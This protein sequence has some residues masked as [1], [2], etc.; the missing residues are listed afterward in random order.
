MTTRPFHSAWSVYAIN[1]CIPSRCH[2]DPVAGE[3]FAFCLFST[4]N[5]RCLAV[6]GMTDTPFVRSLLEL[7]GLRSKVMTQLPGLSLY[8]MFRR[9][10]V[11]STVPSC[12]D[13][14]GPFV[15]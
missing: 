13:V 3:G 7:G 2:P 11:A 15:R 5:S 9:E 12:G 10:Q 14:F 6:L 8:A 4:G 1:G